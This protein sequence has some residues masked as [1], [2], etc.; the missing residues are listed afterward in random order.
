MIGQAARNL[1]G[2]MFSN[3]MHERANGGDF[4]RMA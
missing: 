2:A 1:R 4:A 3:I